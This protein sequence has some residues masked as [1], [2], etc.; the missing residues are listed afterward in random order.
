MMRSFKDNR[1]IYRVWN[2]SQQMNY[3]L[4]VLFIVGGVID[5]F[6]HHAM[7]KWDYLDE[8]IS[9]GYIYEL[10]KRPGIKFYLPLVM[11]DEIQN[12][13]SRNEDYY[14]YELLRH[15]QT[16]YIKPGMTIVDVGANIGNHT[17]FFNKECHAKKIISFEPIKETYEIFIKNIELNGLKDVVRAYNFAIGDGVQHN[18]S[19]EQFNPE[20]IGGTVLSNK[21][22]GEINVRGL[23]ELEIGEKIDFIKIDTEGFEVN[24]IK[25]AADLLKR[26]KPILFVEIAPRNLDAINK[27]LDTLG[28]VM[29]DDLGLANYVYA[30]RDKSAF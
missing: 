19:I 15:I 18:T 3:P 29:V 17:I 16:Q 5:Y 28:Y 7:H 11:Q 23:D 26:D 27:I 14:E 21:D 20:N 24:V 10:G 30:H 1:Y 6:I 2:S 25:G 13:I 22:C 12:L 4:K 8:I 9:N